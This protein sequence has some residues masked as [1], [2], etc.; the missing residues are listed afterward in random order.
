MCGSIDKPTGILFKEPLMLALKRQRVNFCRG[1][2]GLHGVSA[3]KPNSEKRQRCRR[4]G[5]YLW[6]EVFAMLAYNC[7]LLFP[8]THTA[9]PQNATQ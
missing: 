5:I 9:M 3:C 8:T 7:C 4:V 2:L 1:L 6:I